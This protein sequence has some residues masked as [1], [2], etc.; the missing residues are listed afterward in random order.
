MCETDLYSPPVSSE[1]RLFN[2][3]DSDKEDTIFTFNF[4]IK[5]IGIKDDI[6]FTLD[7]NPSLCIGKEQSSPPQE[8]VKEV[9]K[10]YRNGAC[11]FYR[12]TAEGFYLKG[13]IKII[14]FK[15]PVGQF[16]NKQKN[17]LFD[18]ETGHCKNPSHSID[19]LFQLIDPS[20]NKDEQVL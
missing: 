3:P 12:E 10:F 16:D 5:K 4:D 15:T 14:S 6:S 13:T 18:I 11:S 17:F 19:G 7:L 20:V 2:V 9:Y 1:I 8:P